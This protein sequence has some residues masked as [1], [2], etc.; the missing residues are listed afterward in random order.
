MAVNKF[1]VLLALL[2]VGLAAY[3]NGKPGAPHNNTSPIWKGTPKLLKTVENGKLY[4]IGSGDS[5]IKLIHVYGNM[6]QMGY[7]Q[8]LL[9]KQ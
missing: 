1:V 3:C 7:A 2:A 6:Y 5:A 9:L 4:E 8:G